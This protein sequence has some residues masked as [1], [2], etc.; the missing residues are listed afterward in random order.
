[1]FN[2]F[3]SVHVVLVENHIHIPLTDFVPHF[4]VILVLE[5]NDECHR[6]LFFGPVAPVAL[7]VNGA[8]LIEAVDEEVCDRLYI[9][10]SGVLEA[11]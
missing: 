11:I 1:M 10:K 5:R 7:T 6:G 4:G 8:A 2:K 9:E 3:G